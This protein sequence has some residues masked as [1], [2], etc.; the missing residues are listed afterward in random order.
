M[1][2]YLDRAGISD[3]ELVVRYPEWPRALVLS[4]RAELGE[5]CRVQAEGPDQAL[6]AGDSGDV[7]YQGDTGYKK[8]ETV[9]HS[10]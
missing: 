3:Q 7:S 1:A 8:A 4:H 5:S 9:T 6:R 10:K 2:H